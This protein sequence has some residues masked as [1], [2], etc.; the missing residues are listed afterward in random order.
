MAISLIWGAETPEP[1]ATQFCMS[2]ALQDPI[3]HANFREDRLRGFG[4][5][6]GRILAFS[7]DLLSRL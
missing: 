5:A 2:G 7:T 3:T 1:I 4:V 6:R